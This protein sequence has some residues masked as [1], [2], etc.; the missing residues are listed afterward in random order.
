MA[1]STIGD[2][3]VGAYHP[4]I[5][6]ILEGRSL[7]LPLYLA[8]AEQ[9]LEKSNPEPLRKVGA[10]YYTLRDNCKAELGAGDKEY[11]KKAFYAGSSSGQLL[12]NKKGVENLESLVDITIAH[13]NQYVASISKGKFQLTPHDQTKV[14]TYC[15]FKRICRVDAFA[16]GE[17]ES[18][19]DS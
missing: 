3:K 6:D 10:V 16:E 8:V 4:K 11:N 13:A 9:L 5:D 17:T 2:Y 7:Q 18:G 15:S 19:A 1:F 14:C 12:P